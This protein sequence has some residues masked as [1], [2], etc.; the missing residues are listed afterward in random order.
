MRVST[1]SPP[2]G[3][4]AIFPGPRSAPG[5]KRGEA[6]SGSPALGCEPQRTKLRLYKIKRP[7]GFARKRFGRLWRADCLA[8][9][10]IPQQPDLLGEDI[11]SDLVE[12]SVEEVNCRRFSHHGLLSA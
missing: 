12:A 6:V 10:E 4:G 8:A 7:C 9:D 11:I 5:R 3:G 1:C 2:R